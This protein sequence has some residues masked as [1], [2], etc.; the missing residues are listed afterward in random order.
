[1]KSQK[2]ETILGILCI[3]Y[4]TRDKNCYIKIEFMSKSNK[5]S[6]VSKAAN[7]TK[8]CEYSRSRY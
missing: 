3:L 5:N 2:C 4:S 1:M 8:S 7:D 6:S